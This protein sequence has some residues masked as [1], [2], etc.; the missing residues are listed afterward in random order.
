MTICLSD[1]ADLPAGLRLQAAGHGQSKTWTDPSQRRPYRQIAPGLRAHCVAAIAPSPR[2][3]D[4]LH[5]P[6]SL[7]AC[8]W[9]SSLIIRR[10]CLRRGKT[11][12]RNS[13]DLRST[14]GT[15]HCTPLCMEQHV[16]A[17]H[18]ALYMGCVSSNG[19]TAR[20]F[21]FSHSAL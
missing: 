10:S 20:R 2:D 17:I 9:S 4:H 7:A 18:L 5:R 16:Q 19:T 13:T 11:D 14:S 12:P 21:H 3:I 8:T 15:S 6:A 1:V